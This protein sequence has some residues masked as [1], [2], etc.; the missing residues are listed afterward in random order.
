MREFVLDLVQDFAGLAALAAFGF[1][2]MMLAWG[3]SAC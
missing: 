3:L 2:F 1:G